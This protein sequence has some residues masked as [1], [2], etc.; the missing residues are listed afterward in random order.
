MAKYL[1]SRIK[2][3]YLDYD[4]VIARFPQFKTEIDLLLK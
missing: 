4:A 3:G 2:N 1:A